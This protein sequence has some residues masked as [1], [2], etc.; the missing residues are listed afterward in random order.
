MDLRT[1]LEYGVGMV[2]TTVVRREDEYGRMG[3][4]QQTPVWGLSMCQLGAMIKLIRTTYG[5]VQLDL[6]ETRAVCIACLGIDI[7]T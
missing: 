7:F 2:T 1:V 6:H 3:R 4:C 5:L